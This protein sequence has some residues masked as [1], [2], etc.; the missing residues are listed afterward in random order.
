MTQD[1]DF[2]VGAQQGDEAKGMV[3]K[4]LADRADAGGDPYAWTG[5]VGAQ[6]AEHRFVHGACDFTARVLP[7]ASAYRN[8]I[9]ALL[10]A[11]HCFYPEH[12]LLEAVHL[13]M[14]LERIYVDPHAMWLRPDHGE[15]NLQ[16]GN[17][18]GTT[19]WG[20]GAAIAEKVRRQ[21]GTQLIG[22]CDTLRSALGPRLT[23]ISTLISAI[24]GPGLMEGSQG[25]MLSLNHGHYPHCTA[26]DVT[27]PALCAEMGIPVRRVRRVFGVV[28]MVS[29]RVPGPSGPVGSAEITYDDVESRTGLRMPHHKRLQGDTTRWT[30]SN[31]PDQAEEERLFELSMDELAF[32]HNL[33]AYDAIAVTFAD[34]HRRGNYRATSW[35]SLHPD[36]QHAITEI[37]KRIA[38]VVLVRTGQG[39]HDNIWRG[40]FSHGR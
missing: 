2:V 12:L 14:P 17:A 35:D 1:I 15:T 31:R 40:E 20:V 30:A 3:S 9:L 13:G 26:K 24:P 6:N 4:L 7:S 38:P 8:G 29:M 34:Y 25:A 39:E 19:G 28:R 21:P 37:E 11:G 10:G 27:V 5:R 33:N 23:P 22:D 32:T 18:R 36:T 16:T